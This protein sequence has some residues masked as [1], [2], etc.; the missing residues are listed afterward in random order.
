VSSKRNPKPPL[1]VATFLFVVLSALPAPAN[2]EADNDDY[3]SGHKDHGYRS[4]RGHAHHVVDRAD[5]HAPIGVMAEHTH[6]AGDWMVTLRYMRMEMDGNRNNT[7]RLSTSDVRAR[8]YA[9]VPT[10]MDMEM[11]TF[12]LMYAPTDWLTLMAMVPYK[13]LEMDHKAGMPLGAVKFTTRTKGVGD[14]RLAALFP[15]VLEERHRLHATAGVSAPTGSIDEKD[16][17]PLDPGATRNLP[18]PMQIGSGTWDVLLNTTY[19]YERRKWSA[20]SQLSGVVRT[21]E[22][23]NDYTLGDRF[24]AT[25]WFQYLWVSEVSTSIRFNYEWWDNIDGSDPDLGAAPFVVPTADPDL[26]GGQRLDMLFGI[27]IEPKGVLKGHRFAIESG[28]P[29]YQDLDGPQLETDWIFTA[30]WQLS[31]Y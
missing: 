19:V 28:L 31:F 26:R 6:G 10:R 8:G 16:E 13:T 30:G 1:L 27:N 23:D 7:S 9:V 25:G 2:A 5:S 20:G 17:T 14:I 21:G 15:L 22:N 12:G 29:V 24:N 11:F 4:A 18:Y 3:T